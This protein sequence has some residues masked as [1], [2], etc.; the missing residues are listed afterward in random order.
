[1]GAVDSSALGQG[2]MAGSSEYSN[3]PSG[4]T[5]IAEKLHSS[6]EGLCSME[7]VSEKA[8]QKRYREF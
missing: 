3:D 7:S 2:P 1:M 4:S 8:V 6:Q 5:E